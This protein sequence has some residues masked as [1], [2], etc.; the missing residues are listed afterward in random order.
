VLGVIGAFL[1]KQIIMKKLVLVS[2]LAIGLF[3]CQ[4]EEVVQQ[5]VKNCNCDR[6]VKIVAYTIIAS[7]PQ[8][9]PTNHA[10]IYT[11]NDCTN[12]NDWDEWKSTEY[13]YF[14]KVGDCK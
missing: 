5:P 8:G 6:I 12:F 7:T 9:K 2:V 13:K 10:T 1:F 3:S 4:K 14:K 11:V